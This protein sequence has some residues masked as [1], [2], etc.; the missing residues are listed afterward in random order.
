MNTDLGNKPNGSKWDDIDFC[1][2]DGWSVD[3]IHR[4]TTIVMVSILF[5]IEQ[6]V[7]YTEI[8]LEKEVQDTPSS[9]VT[10]WSHNKHT[11]DFFINIG[12]HQKEHLS[13][14]NWYEI[15]L[16]FKKT[17]IQ[18]LYD[19]LSCKKRENGE[20][21]FVFWDQECLNFG[22]DWQRGFLLGFVNTKVIVLLISAQVL[23]NI[24]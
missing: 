12:F 24:K 22:Q 5:M 20:S 19:S 9:M 2:N 23:Y 13:Q 16:F 4:S 1:W 6:C 10:C 17:V 21:I 3:C 8:V 18:V 14:P 15:V 7:F 11:H